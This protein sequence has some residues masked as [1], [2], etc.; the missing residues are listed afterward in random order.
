MKLV[1]ILSPEY[2]EDVQDVGDFIDDKYERIPMK[3]NSFI[4]KFFEGSNFE[5]L[6]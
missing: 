6:R 2:S 4:T 1:F 3:C 5:E